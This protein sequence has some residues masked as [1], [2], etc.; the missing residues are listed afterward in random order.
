MK[1]ILSRLLVIRDMMSWL[2]VRLLIRLLVRLLIGLLIGLLHLLLLWIRILKIWD[3]HRNQLPIDFGVDWS[4]FPGEY[5][6]KEN[7]TTEKQSNLNESFSSFFS[8]LLPF[9]LTHLIEDVFVLLILI[10]SLLSFG[11]KIAFEGAKGSHGIVLF[12]LIFIREGLVGLVYLLEFC[13]V[14]RRVIR[15]ILFG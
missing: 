12:S 3:L 8:N 2:L 5:I 9:F 10:V 13:L 4:W 1:A 11:A 7:K 6:P 15:M 14:S